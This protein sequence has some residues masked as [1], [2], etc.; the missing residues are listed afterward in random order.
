MS[1]RAN[2]IDTFEGRAELLAIALDV[3][4]EAGKIVERGWRHGVRAEH[5]GPV[6]LVTTFDRESEKYLREA[7]HARTSFAVTGEEEGADAAKSAEEDAPTWYVDP[8]DGTTNFVHGHFF[9][10]VSVGLSRR[11]EPILG[12]IVAPSLHTE[13]TGLIGVGGKSDVALRNDE[14]CRVSVVDQFTDSLLATGFPYDRKND[15]ENN[16]DAFVS[17][18]KSCQ[19]V[20]RCGSAALDLCLVADGTYD[21]YWERGLKPW[22]MAAGAAILA[23]AGGKLS[24]YDGAAFD[25]RR[26]E[27]VATNGHIHAALTHALARVGR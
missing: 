10:C 12:A 22:D 3:A 1:Q 5:K 25:V 13:W 24:G 15:R 19:A 18:K 17:I 9:Y 26:P 2:D 8:I 11:N 6:D 23:A 4:R 16:F 7:L 27:V 21:G 14:P 20:R